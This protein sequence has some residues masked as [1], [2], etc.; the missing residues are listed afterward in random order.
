MFEGFAGGLLN[1][2][3][4][5]WSSLKD[6]AMQRET[7]ALNY[8]MWQEGL[9]YNKPANQVARLKEAGLNPALMYG[10]GS[11]ATVGAPPPRAEAP[12]QGPVRVDP[13]SIATVQQARL[14]GE[15]AALVREQTRGVKLENDVIAGA[16]GSLKKDSAPVRAVR[17]ALNSG[18]AAEVK[19]GLQE[20]RSNLG[21][22]PVKRLWDDAKDYWGSA[23]KN[24]LGTPSWMK[25][26][27]KSDPGAWK[28]GPNP[29]W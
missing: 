28:K 17:E 10:N 7:N 25:A 8:R 29:K 13:G 3:L 26:K 27:P 11:A 24:S 19:A 16:P 14:A 6:Q 21:Q 20:L 1:A 15:Q 4:D 18:T 9:E 12:R 2:G 5:Y 23:I 22:N